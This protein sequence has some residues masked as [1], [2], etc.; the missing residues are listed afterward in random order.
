MRRYASLLLIAL[1]LTGGARGALITQGTTA[2]RFDHR[3]HQGV[4]PT[5]TGCHA[6]VVSGDDSSAAAAYPPAAVCNECHGA[7]DTARL[8]R[9]DTTRRPRLDTLRVLRR[10]AWSAPH[11][12]PTNLDFWHLEHAREAG[13]GVATTECARCHQLPGDSAFMAVGRARP[14]TCIG[15]HDHRASAHLADDS[16]CAVCHVPVARARALSVRRVAGFQ[17]PPSHDRPDF[18][19]RHAPDERAEGTGRGLAGCAVCHSRE[20]CA[21]CHV[22]AATLPSVTR[23]ASDARVAAAVAGKAGRYPVPPSHRD[24]E[25]VYD[26]GPQART[27]VASCGS[28]HARASCTSCHI[29]R[30]AQDVIRQ[31]PAPAAGAAAGVQLERR[32]GGGLDAR[33]DR[34]AII[35]TTSSARWRSTLLPTAR[36]RTTP[37][38][39]SVRHAAPDD[40]TRARG[41]TGTVQGPTA[42]R[43]HPPG[44]AREHGA[45]AATQELT[46]AGCHEQRFCSSCHTGEGRRRYHPPNFVARHAPESYGRE[47]DCQSCHNP[48][49]FCRGCHQG[50]GLAAQGRLD[51]AFHTAQPQWFIEHGRAARQGLA[52][53][54][55]CH[56]QLDCMQCHSERTRRVSP[57]GPNFD[58]DRMGSRSLGTCLNCHISD[59]RGRR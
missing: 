52:S 54:T 34:E 13:F 2:D 55:S 31:L 6:G 28:C 27:G 10:V 45:S 29:G 53:C 18:I 41:D 19:S 42:V 15:C 17:R 11:T 49:V 32:A 44:F 35:P 56:K 38:A 8:R 51:V 37:A 30:G 1:A 24:P 7:T 20:S 58:P 50:T 36:H 33:H 16:R 26:H 3:E 40:T 12:E 5:C 9:A 39:V 22:N 59:P 25:F 48:E 21:R 47:R 43:V 57:H 14:E 23:L 4:F 46:C